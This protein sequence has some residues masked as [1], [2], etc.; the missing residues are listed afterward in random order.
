VE[1][2]EILTMAS[3]QLSVLRVTGALGVVLFGFFFLLTFSTPQWVE[4]F[5]VEFI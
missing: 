4:Q 2:E 3:T 1:S 5:A